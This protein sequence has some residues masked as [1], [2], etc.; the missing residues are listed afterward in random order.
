MLFVA[1]YMLEGLLLMLMARPMI[2]RRVRPNR[3]YGFRTPKTLSSPAI[4]YPAN[5][6]SGR[7]LFN[8]GAIITLFSLV[9][10]PLNLLGK[11]GATFYT[12]TMVGIM[13]LSLFSGVIASFR[14]LKR[15]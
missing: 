9:L 7:R 8:S 15:L 10:A 3:F 5:E 2:K 4:W 1:V 13:L 6:F 12:M 11:N 14:Y